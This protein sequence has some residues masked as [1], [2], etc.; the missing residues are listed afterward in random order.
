VITVFPCCVVL[1]EL[2]FS[3]N[4]STDLADGEPDESDK[5]EFEEVQSIF[6]KDQTGR[7]LHETGMLDSRTLDVGGDSNFLLIKVNF[8]SG[9]ANFRLN[10]HPFLPLA[11][12]RPGESPD[13]H[14]GRNT[15]TISHSIDGMVEFVINKTETIMAKRDAVKTDRENRGGSLMSLKRQKELKWRDDASDT[16]R[17]LT[18]EQSA[19]KMQ[20]LLSRASSASSTWSPRPKRSPETGFLQ[21]PDT[22]TAKREPNRKY[23]TLLDVKNA[24]A[25][26]MSLSDFGSFISTFS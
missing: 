23:N 25:S 7:L 24:I 26:S 18:S 12:G 8:H 6:I 11:S 21:L 2:Y 15:L 13:L 3:K 20:I 17:G 22:S 5:E 1:W 16:S 9:K 19:P 4:E 10:D 14:V